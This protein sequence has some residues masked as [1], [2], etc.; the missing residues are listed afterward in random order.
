MKYVGAPDSFIKLPFVVEGLLLG[1]ISAL[2]AF[3]LEWLV[4]DYIAERLVGAAGLMDMA[5]FSTLSLPLLGILLI[6]GLILG[7]GGSVATIRKFLKV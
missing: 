6:A 4:Y 5:E 2:I 7:S 1:E 3:G